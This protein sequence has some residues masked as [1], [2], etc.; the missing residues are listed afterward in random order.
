MRLVFTLPWFDPAVQFGGPVAQTRQLSRVLARRGHDVRIV[1]TDNGVPVDWPRDRWVD[2]EGYQVWYARTGPLNRVAPYYAPMLHRPLTEALRGAD[3]LHLRVG[4]TLVNALARRLALR[5]G[6]PYVYNA[7]GVLCPHRLRIKRGAKWLFLRLFERRILRDAAALQAV[8]AREADD[9]RRQGAD[10]ARIHVI[11]N[12][13]D[14]VSAEAG[15]SGRLFRE[16]FAIPDTARLVLFLGRLHHIKGLDLLAGVVARLAVRHPRL[17][18]AVAGPDEGY[19][20]A[21]GRQA[22]SLGIGD[23]LRLTGLLTGELQAAA[24]RAA[25]VFALTS[26]TEGL[27]NA[28]LEACA[29][30]VPAL[31]TDR[32]NLPEVAEYDAGRVEPPDVDRLTHSLDE[33]LSDPAALA[34]MGRNARRMIEERFSLSRVVSDLEALCERLARG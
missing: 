26:Y 7:E 27:P 4:L 32:C 34:R 2:R 1:T 20:A 22:E 15:P 18:L 14:L 5:H 9:L 33:M 8:T 12:G 13:V 30:G 10:P 29:A 16:R 28:V 23:R 25:D 31:V 24:L 17:V 21:L 3:V 11:P 19:Q 6:V